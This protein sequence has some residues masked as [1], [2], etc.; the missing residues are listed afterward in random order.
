MAYQKQGFVVGQTLTAAQMNH[1]EAGISALDAAVEDMP[2]EYWRTH[3]EARVED[4]RAAL[5]AAGRDKSSFLWYHDS[6]W[7]QNNKVSPLLLKYLHAHTA[8]NKT[9]FGGDI[10]STDAMTTREDIKYLY[11]WRD[12]IR[13]LPNHH[14][15][16]GNHDYDIAG[17]TSLKNIYAFLLAAEETNDIV[18]GGD[19][20][21]YIDCPCEKTRYLYLDTGSY[22]ETGYDTIETAKEAQFIIDA[23]KTVEDGWHVVAI[24]HIWYIYNAQNT[25]DDGYIPDI[26]KTIL[27][28]FDAYNSR[29]AGSFED[30]SYDFTA[31]KGRVEFCIGGHTHSDYSFATSGGIPVIL[32]E[33]DSAQVRSPELSSTAGT[34][35]ENAVSAIVADYGAG[36]IKVI[37]VGRGSSFTVDMDGEAGG[38]DTPAYINQIPLSTDANGNP[39]NG[40]KGWKADTRL[41]SDGSESEY[42]GTE[43]TGFIP[44]VMGDVI[45]FYNMSIPGTEASVGGSKSYFAIYDAA[46]NKI[47]STYT[48][49]I[50]QGN[51]GENMELDAD[52][53]WTYYNTSNIHNFMT[54]A[55]KNM[56]YFRVSA[57]NITDDSIITIE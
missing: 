4:I 40:G 30:V 44:C 22:F 25:P 1:I 19:F 14:S 7:T 45:R 26:C 11:E 17:F 32:T 48:Y 37:R 36:K 23:L 21:Y 13:D 16:V 47:S 15:V 35:T 38:G 8:I 33:T 18:Y 10:V 54:E 20:Y 5:E 6:H 2:P 52:G 24:S 43:T 56:A 9:N 49:Q 42:A 51:Q 46:K 29:S 55:A 57:L 39:Y 3:L 28:L 53:Y 50:A 34:I 27:S 41:N 12:A 31:V